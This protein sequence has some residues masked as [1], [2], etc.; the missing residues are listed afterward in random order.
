MF[1][2]DR[3]QEMWDELADWLDEQADDHIYRGMRRVDQHI[4]LAYG[5]VRLKMIEMELQGVEGEK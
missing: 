1:G 4:G 3:Y 5:E 2:D